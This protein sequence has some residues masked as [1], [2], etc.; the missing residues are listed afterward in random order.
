MDLE[1]AMQETALLVWSK[2]HQ[3]KD[4]TK[5]EGWCIR[6]LENKCKEMKRKRRREVLVSLEEL[7]SV[8]YAITPYFTEEMI[9]LKNCLEQLNEPHRTTMKLHY[10]HDLSIEEIASLLAIPEGTVKSRI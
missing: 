4:P 10:F 7:N 2:I 1:D 5:F 8:F 9:D 3:L 6:I